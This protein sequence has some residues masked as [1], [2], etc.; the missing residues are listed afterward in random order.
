MGN[1]MQDKEHMIGFFNQRSDEIVDAIAPDRL[2]VYRVEEGWGPLCEFLG[3]PVPETEF[4]RINSRDETRQLLAGLIAS[5][6]GQVS[7]EAMRE[8]GSRLHEN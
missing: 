6:D 1:R 4:P 8:A 5:R 3:V 7:E 2:L